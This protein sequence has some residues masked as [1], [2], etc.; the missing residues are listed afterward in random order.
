M[1]PPKTFRDYI[2][3]DAYA[4]SI[5]LK[6]EGRTGMF[7]LATQESA[8][9]EI[10]INLLRR[11]S[12]QLEK[13]RAPQALI[14]QIRSFAG[15]LYSVK[16]AGKP[17]HMKKA[18]T[19]LKNFNLFLQSDV[20]SGVN[21]YSRLL[22]LAKEKGFELAQIG[23][24][25]RSITES[26]EL[27]LTLDQEDVRDG[28]E[29]QPYKVGELLP[30]EEIV[31]APEE[32]PLQPLRQR[33]VVNR[34]LEKPA[35]DWIKQFQTTNDIYELRR[36]QA[37]NPVPKT[38]WLLR[39]L[40]VRSLVNA[41]PGDKSF[42]TTML[43]LQQIDQRAALLAQDPDMQ[44]FLRDVKSPDYYTSVLEA[45][46]KGTGSGLDTKL[47]RY[48]AFFGMAPR[49]E[50]MTRYL[51]SA[52]LRVDCQKYVLKNKAEKREDK[53]DCVSQIIASRLTVGARRGG[54]TGMDDRMKNAPD[55]EAFAQCRK[56]TRDALEKL[57]PAELGSLLN[58]S[59]A[60]HGGKMLQRFTALTRI[61][62][63]NWQDKV[64]EQQGPR[65]EEQPEL[66]RI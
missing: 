3:F 33:A 20:G 26:L 19:Q 54:L 11:Y 7:G 39:L 4:D 16:A 45:A 58:L 56:L 49:G 8:D 52:E 62:A 55:S 17:E 40:A 57:A 30:A 65:I 63:Q 61:D 9:A 18:L 59:Q 60:G 34:T 22:R 43:S 14:D 23:R 5:F 38:D 13:E 36:D 12:T 29:T 44:A 37:G 66:L 48:F 24:G 35:K 53:L 27:G 47:K 51:P 21:H 28:P 15:T 10:I 64:R 1:A 31:P 41:R 25:F 2:S 46:K 50:L 42:H 32:Q 6:R